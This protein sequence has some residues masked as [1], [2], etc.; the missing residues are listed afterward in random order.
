LLAATA[1]G[2]RATRRAALT[3]AEAKGASA[4]KPSF[5]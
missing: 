4:L 2:L 3:E 1:A 5:T